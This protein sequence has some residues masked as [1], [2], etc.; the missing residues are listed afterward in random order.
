MATLV[1]VFSEFFRA[2]GYT[3]RTRTEL[4]GT[5]GRRHPV[6]LLLEKDTRRVAVAFWLHRQPLGPT[7]VAELL[8]AIRDTACDGGLVVSLGA[9][10][11]TLT[12]H[13]AQNRVQVWD[14]L[15]TTQE[16]GSAVV[17]ETCPDVWEQ[18]DPWATPRPSRILHQVH[19]AALNATPATP[20]APAAAPTPVPTPAPAPTP[21]SP[22][23]EP[24]FPAAIPP[25][26]AAP[27]TQPSPILEI[28]MAFG[29]LDQAVQPATAAPTPPAPAP[30]TPAPTVAPSFAPAP[31]PRPAR[32]ILRTQV[33]KSL[34]L[35]LAKP[36]TRTIDRVFLRLVPCHV[37]DYEAQV[38][39]EGSLHADT[40]TG[41]VCVDASTKRVKPWVHALDVGEVALEGADVDEKPIRLPS[42]EAQKILTNEL[43]SLV[44][45][46]VVTQEDESEWSVIVK[47]K[48]ELAENE[49]RLHNLGVYWV[50]IWRVAG[51]DGSIE[52]DAATGQ[53]VFEEI[54]APKADALLL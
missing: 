12:V 40:Q 17:R 39:V 49:L 53:V 11:E 23:S 48:V 22:V 36:K 15:R 51:R 34:A 28:P 27:E 38:L 20:P 10:P 9:V 44:T 16:L 46:D 6:A 14:S 30:P 50:P 43:R 29:I 54:T 1:D 24:P 45:R 3:T 41:R 42:D 47:K 13:A 52:I 26:L 37:F 7:F 33:S 21:A 8:E 2:F 19:Q 32:R 31:I 5:S 25:L 4:P 18:Q 35:S